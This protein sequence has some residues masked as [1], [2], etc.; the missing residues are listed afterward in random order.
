MFSTVTNN[1]QIVP[2]VENIAHYSSIQLF[3]PTER[4]VEDK[5]AKIRGFFS[6]VLKYL[7]ATY[8][9]FAT[10][11]VERRVLRSRAANLIKNIEHSIKQETF[12]F[13]GRR[14][15]QILTPWAGKFAVRRALI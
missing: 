7:T 3:F 11:K 5:G 6:T 10:G 14:I 1:L 4:R 9:A 15:T 8:R 13:L 12:V 2:N